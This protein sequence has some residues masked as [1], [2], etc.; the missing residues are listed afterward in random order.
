MTPVREMGPRWLKTLQ[1]ALVEQRLTRREIN[2]RVGKAK[3]MIKWATAE[4]MIPSSIFHALQAVEGL[5][6]GR[7][8]AKER[9][10]VRPVAGRSREVS[11]HFN[12][13]GVA[14]SGNHWTWIVGDS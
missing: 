8:G 1:H 3:R 7:S 12:D 2:K 6:R 14:H 4:E 9:E 5:R 10:P 11:V 13:A